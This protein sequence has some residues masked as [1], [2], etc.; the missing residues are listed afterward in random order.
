M[1]GE[2]DAIDWRLVEDEAALRDELKRV[3]AKFNSPGFGGDGVAPNVKP[4]RYPCL[5]AWEDRYCGG[6][7]MWVPWFVYSRDARKLQRAVTRLKQAARTKAKQA[8][9][10]KA[11]QERK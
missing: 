3:R 6:N 10:T 7:Y 5:I 2:S 4:E 8:A 11:K 1:S 9:R